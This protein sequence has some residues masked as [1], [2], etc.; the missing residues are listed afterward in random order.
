[1]GPKSNHK[2]MARDDNVC[3]TRGEKKRVYYFLVW[4]EGYEGLQVNPQEARGW[5][6]NLT[7]AATL[8]RGNRSRTDCFE[9]KINYRSYSSPG[10]RSRPDC[11]G[12]RITTRSAVSS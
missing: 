3:N 5:K 1:M 7:T 10:N 2:R 4:P 8:P 6:Q 12:A 9:A 11:F